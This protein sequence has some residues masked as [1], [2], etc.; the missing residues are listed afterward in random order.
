M[1][2]IGVQQN[3]DMERAQHEEWVRG[4]ATTDN[5]C[6]GLKYRIP[7]ATTN[8]QRLVNEFFADSYLIM[9]RS[10]IKQL[11]LSYS[12]KYWE[13]DYNYLYQYQPP[14]SIGPVLNPPYYYCEG[15]WPA[16]RN[17]LY[18]PPL[19]SL[20]N[21]MSNAF[22]RTSI[23]SN[24]SIGATI[25]YYLPATYTPILSDTAIVTSLALLTFISMLLWPTY[26]YR[27]IY[28]R[29]ER[30][31]HMMRI[32]GLK[33]S[34]YWIANYFFDYLMLVTNFIHSRTFI[35]IGVNDDDVC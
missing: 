23:G 26:T 8:L 30:L 11:Q 29:E 28:E 32:S 4:N 21:S 34:T 2:S 7:N 19:P 33:V 9:S 15:P 13:T 31:F 35:L 16:L 6:G 3:M 1:I 10:S 24:T 17:S 5:Y 22:G 18:S 25:N 20:V 27:I 12:F 14:W